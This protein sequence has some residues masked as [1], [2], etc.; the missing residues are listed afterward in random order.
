MVDEEWSEYMA[1][2]LKLKA[3]DFFRT[4]AF[5]HNKEG[6]NK[7]TMALLNSEFNLYRGLFPLKVFLTGPPASGK[8]HFAS[9]LAQTYGI[10][11][12]KV[13]DLVSMGYKLQDSFGEEIRK[14]AEEIK[15]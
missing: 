11:H 6:I 13:S 5:W 10:P 9:Y 12:F 8:T 4:A 14:K 2:D 15:D 1:I 7:R 3:S